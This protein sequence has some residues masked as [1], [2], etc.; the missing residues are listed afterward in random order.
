[1]HS[2]STAEQ[3][4]ARDKSRISLYAN[5]YGRE[6][7]YASSKNSG[8]TLP[9]DVADSIM[10]E[11]YE[12]PVPVDPFERSGKSREVKP[13]IAPTSPDASSRLP[14]GRGLDAPLGH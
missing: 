11:D 13:Y 9:P 1:M 5:L 8:T 10:E 6:Y 2:I 14:F 7:K 12:V 4:E 3:G